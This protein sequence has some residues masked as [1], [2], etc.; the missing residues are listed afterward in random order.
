MISGGVTLDKP[1]CRATAEDMFYY[2]VAFHTLCKLFK[3]RREEGRAELPRAVGRRQKNTESLL[4]LP[5]P[6][7]S[8]QLRPLEQRW[9]LGCHGLTPGRSLNQSG[10]WKTGDARQALHRSS[11][12]N[13][14]DDANKKKQHKALPAWLLLLLFSQVRNKPGAEPHR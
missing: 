4:F 7:Q 1:A 3:Q 8:S 12:C 14:H 2:Y 10:C 6:S 11:R 5:A 9:T 13:R